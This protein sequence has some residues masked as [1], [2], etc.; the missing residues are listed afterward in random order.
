M[1]LFLQHFYY[2]RTLTETFFIESVLL[3]PEILDFRPV[4]LEKKRQLCKAFLEFSKSQ[5]ILSL[6]STSSKVSVTEVLVQQQA[7]DSSCAI[8]FNRNCRCFP[9]YFPKFLVQQFHNIVIK[10]S[11]L[12]FSR[13]LGSR[14]Q[15][16]VLIKK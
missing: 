13:V 15:P 11:T 8:S 7:V 5:N 9:G 3:K 6:L 14:P 16:Y 2:F 1:D 10:L 12:Q 4:A